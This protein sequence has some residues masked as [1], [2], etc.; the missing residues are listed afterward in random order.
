MSCCE[1][2]INLSKVSAVMVLF[3]DTVENTTFEIWNQNFLVVLNC[4]KV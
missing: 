3:L 1:L 4:Q 2:S